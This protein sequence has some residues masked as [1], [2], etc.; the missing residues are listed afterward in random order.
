MHRRSILIGIGIGII[1]GALLVELFNL[2]STSQQ[3]L[4]KMELSMNLAGG[5]SGLFDTSNLPDE[6]SSIKEESGGPDSLSEIPS[7]EEVADEEV[8]NSVSDELLLLNNEDNDSNNESPAMEDELTEELQEEGIEASVS[9]EAVK[10]YILRVEPGKSI[11]Y[12]AKLL[13]SHQIIADQK[14]FISLLIKNKTEIRAGYFFVEQNS[15]NERLKKIITSTPLTESQWKS[16]TE[17]EGI[18]IIL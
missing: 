3:R 13:Q 16:Y 6:N 7:N 17:D 5:E 9:E 4:E 2:G 8:T 1:I 18:E 14:S 11:S 15:S 10:A 12:V